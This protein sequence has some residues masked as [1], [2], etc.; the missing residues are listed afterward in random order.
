MHCIPAQCV[1]I[2]WRVLTVVLEIVSRLIRTRARATRICQRRR[3]CQRFLYDCRRVGRGNDACEYCGP[4]DVHCRRQAIRDFCKNQ[5]SS[6]RSLPCVL[7]S[8]VNT[9]LTRF[10]RDLANVDK[11]QELLDKKADEEVCAQEIVVAY[12]SASCRKLRR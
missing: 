2:K 8:D 4:V 11:E 6:T 1:A 9:T 10:L 3:V 12:S 7:L 5:L